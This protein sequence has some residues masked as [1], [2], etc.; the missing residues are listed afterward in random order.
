[1]IEK[2][3]FLFLNSDVTVNRQSSLTVQIEGRRLKSVKPEAKI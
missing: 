1:M 2:I 3:K